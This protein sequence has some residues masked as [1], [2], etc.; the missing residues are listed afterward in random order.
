MFCCYAHPMRERSCFSPFHFHEEPV[1]FF[2]S[3]DNI[4]IKPR[5]K[6][7]AGAVC[8]DSN[9]NLLLWILKIKSGPSFTNR[10]AKVNFHFK[11]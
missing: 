7:F 10:R 11:I 6:L 3:D 2:V 1:F 9:D 4:R 5:K 8:D